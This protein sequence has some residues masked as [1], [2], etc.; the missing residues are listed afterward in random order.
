MNQRYCVL[1]RDGLPLTVLSNKLEVLGQV[2]IPGGG[3]VRQLAWIPGTDRCAI[4]T[5]TGD[6]LQL[7]SETQQINT[8]NS[9]FAGNCLSMHW[10]DSSR[11]WLGIKPSAAVLLNTSSG[12]IEAALHACQNG[13]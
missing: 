6:L 5:H 3:R 8:L 10:L 11:V 2:E 1:A 9:E 7:D 12:E 4:V 13:L